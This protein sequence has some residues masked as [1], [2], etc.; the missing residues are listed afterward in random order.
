MAVIS[1]PTGWESLVRAVVPA[2]EERDAHR[3]AALLSKTLLES[4]EN[5]VVSPDA[6]ES[7]G[8]HRRRDIYQ[9]FSGSVTPPIGIPLP[10]GESM[11][12]EAAT[13]LMSEYE[14]EFLDAR[15]PEEINLFV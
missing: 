10:V 2:I 13:Q 4:T 5:I 9:H 12:H 7:Y 6:W 1:F 15:D 3:A 14:P 8:P 11:T